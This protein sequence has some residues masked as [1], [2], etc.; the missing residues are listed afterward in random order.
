MLKSS[1]VFIRLKL[2]DLWHL[3][4]SLKYIFTI[5]QV[6][7][8]CLYVPNKIC[9]NEQL[10]HWNSPYDILFYALL[11]LLSWDKH[12]FVMC[13]CVYS[14]ALCVLFIFPSVCSYVYCF[15]CNS[16]RNSVDLILS[17]ARFLCL[18]L[19]GDCRYK[20]ACSHNLVQCIKWW[21]SQ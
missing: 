14:Y 11:E 19:P 18:E 7:S 16:S 10:R 6:L 20:L 4:T 17:V 2:Q 3:E 21:Q 8:K 12:G 1:V 13:L 9:Y 15:S 5:C